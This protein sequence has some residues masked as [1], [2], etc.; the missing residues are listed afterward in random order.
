MKNL[1]TITWLL[2][3]IGALNWGVY[4]LFGWEIGQL[5]GGMDA[6]ATKVV[7]ILIGASAV[8]ELMSHKKGCKPCSK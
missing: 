5:L 4:A 2:V 3:V 1:H 8:L 6:M 7:Y